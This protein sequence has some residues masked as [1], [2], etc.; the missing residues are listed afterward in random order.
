MINDQHLFSR[1][2]ETRSHSIGVFENTIYGK[3]SQ[4][5]SA[6]INLRSS[7]SVRP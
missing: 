5:E 6:E 2:T 7:T 1:V 3:V 4:K